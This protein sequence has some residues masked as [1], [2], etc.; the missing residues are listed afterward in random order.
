M[1]LSIKKNNFAY[2]SLKLFLLGILLFHKFP[3]QNKLIIDSI[4][5]I[6]ASKIADT[7]RVYCLIKLS[8]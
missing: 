5:K 2:L 7:T 3:A 6:L 4:E 1:F 8:D